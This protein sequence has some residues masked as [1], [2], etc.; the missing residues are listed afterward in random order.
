MCQHAFAQSLIWTFVATLLNNQSKQWHGFH[1]SDVINE[2]AHY[3]NVKF[4]VAM[5]YDYEKDVKEACSMLTDLEGATIVSI[6]VN[7]VDRNLMWST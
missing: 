2:H 4:Q 3:A 5:T 7:V 1:W 6:R